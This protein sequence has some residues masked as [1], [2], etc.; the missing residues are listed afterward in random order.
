YLDEPVERIEELLA[1]S[2]NPKSLEGSISDDGSSELMDV[3]ADTES[4]NPKRAVAERMIQDNILQVLSQLSERE[5]KIIS[6]RYGLLGS[7]PMT[8]E[9][10]GQKI[11]VTR[12]R[13]RQIAEATVTKM[14]EILKEKNLDYQDF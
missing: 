7:Q 3:V 10:I 11:G 5:A 9:E 1:M 13:V 2:H 14:Y 4:V 12:E 8:L 6:W